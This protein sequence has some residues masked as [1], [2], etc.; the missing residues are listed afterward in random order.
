MTRKEDIDAG[1]EKG[2]VPSQY[3][4]QITDFF[5][6]IRRAFGFPLRQESPFFPT[7]SNLHHEPENESRE[8]KSMASVYPSEISSCAVIAT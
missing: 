4:L 1:K 7:Y 6:S 3:C 8:K 2:D 5:S